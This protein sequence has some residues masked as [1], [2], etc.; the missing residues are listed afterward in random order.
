MGIPEDEAKQRALDRNTA[1][2]VSLDGAGYL[3]DVLSLETL[4]DALGSALIGQHLAIVDEAV[5][6]DAMLR[7][8]L[9][10]VDIED[11]LADKQ[12]ALEKFQTSRQVLAYHIA[13][14]NY[15]L[16]AREY[17]VQVESLIM[18]AK[19]FAAAVE[20]E[21]LT[22]EIDRAQMDLRREQAH[23]V[24]IGAQILIEQ[25]EQQRVQVDIA[26]AQ[27]DVAK[28]GVDVVMADVAIKEAQV[29]LVDAE[30][31]I[32]MADV[33]KATLQADIATIYADIIV[34]GLAKIRYYVESAEIDVGFSVIQE[35][36]T[37]TLNL[38]HERTLVE[39][40]VRQYE[41]SELAELAHL[42]TAKEAL[43]DLQTASQQ[44]TE[45]VWAFE[46][47]LSE[48]IKGE[49]VT[50]RDQ[51]FTERQD[52]AKVK[53]AGKITVD[54]KDLWAHRILNAAQRWVYTNAI[55]ASQNLE[56]S[57]SLY[58]KG[59]I[60]PPLWIDTLMIGEDMCQ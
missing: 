36:L 41:E 18:T 56:Y 34:R 50:V 5:N 31:E 14:E 53:S 29:K 51:E 24:E 2:W 37:D 9:Y 52:V 38:V 20:R 47:A 1:L 21:S 19:E 58:H 59:V 48:E 32:A 25:Y 49:E 57:S 26:R 12:I 40:L 15:L 22:L 60:T 28:A 33:D 16:A 43:E 27:L 8:K 3:T 10:E 4:E 54:N 6:W 46:K 44:A 39:N 42:T 45:D 13:G 23:L 35:K 55:H 17:E 7:D 30:F 11:V